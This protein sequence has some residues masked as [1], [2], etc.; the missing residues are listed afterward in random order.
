MTD[1]K[2]AELV[3]IKLVIKGKEI[4][5]SLEDAKELTEVLAKMFGEKKTEYIPQPYPCPYPVERPYSPYWPYEI[6]WQSPNWTT[7]DKTETLT[8]RYGDLYT[9]TSGNCGLS[10]I[11]NGGE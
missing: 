2:K 8:V 4:E 1:K 3:G 9:T 11:L 10:C 6:I 5:L 7:T